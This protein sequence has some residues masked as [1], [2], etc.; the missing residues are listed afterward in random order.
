M[1]LVGFLNRSRSYP[2]PLITVGVEDGNFFAFYPSGDKVKLRGVESVEA[3]RGRDSFVAAGE[4]K[5][6][7]IP[8]L[9][10]GISPK[11]IVTGV[12]R[13]IGRLLRTYI[14]HQ[15]PLVQGE[16]S[17][18]IRTFLLS[19]GEFT[20][21]I[22]ARELKDILS[23]RRNLTVKVNSRQLR[24]SPHTAGTLLVQL[25]SASGTKTLYR[26]GIPRGRNISDLLIPE[27]TTRF[28]QQALF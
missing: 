9:A 4:T 12:E 17:E 13:D 11:Q 19:I 14:A 22:N 20:G 23:G 26:K 2:A 7:A 18:A 16:D 24:R 27:P 25:A 3:L 28:L 15:G 10:F 1:N 8:K 5:T 21:R 6:D